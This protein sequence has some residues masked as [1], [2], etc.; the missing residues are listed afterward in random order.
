VLLSFGQYKSRKVRE[1]TSPSAL[2]VIEDGR[3]IEKSLKRELMTHE[4]LNERLRAKGIDGPEMVR[5][6]YIE[7]DGDISA[8]L[9]RED[10]RHRIVQAAASA[11]AKRAE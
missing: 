10:E 4:E 11:E 5:V 1:I 2:K 6:G 7:S 9:Y 8:L 3:I